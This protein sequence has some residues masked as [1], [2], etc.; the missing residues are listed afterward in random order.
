MVVNLMDFPIQVDAIKGH[1]SEIPNTGA[2]TCISLKI[3]Y[4]HTLTNGADPGE[5]SY[6]ASFHLGIHCLPMC[7]FVHSVKHADTTIQCVRFGSNFI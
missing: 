1:R 4:T 2:F 3:V 5:I 7:A 6:F